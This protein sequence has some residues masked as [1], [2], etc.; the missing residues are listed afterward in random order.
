MNT[1]SVLK[2]FSIAFIW[3]VFI[4]VVSFVPNSSL[5]EV[6]LNFFEPDKLAH[7]AVYC[8]LNASLLWGFWQ[9]ERL[10]SRTIWLSFGLSCAYGILIECAQYAFF[11]GRYFEFYDIIANMIGSLPGLIVAFFL[12]K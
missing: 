6:K 5:P 10:K 8:L 7:A 2:Y 12:I 1:T 9:N 11:P 3:S 4:A